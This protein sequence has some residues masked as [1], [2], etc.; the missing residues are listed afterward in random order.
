LS[1]MLTNAIKY[2]KPNGN[3][4][5]EVEETDE[6]YTLR[7]IDDGVGI[8]S[9]DLPHVF[10]K[11]YRSDNDKIRQR[12]GHGLGL[13]LS[14]D[15]VELHHGRVNVESLEGE[16]ATFTLTLSKQNTFHNEVAA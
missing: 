4:T 12:S 1:N 7:V 2:N 14:K 11:F 9:I 3:V 15:I 5:L 16:G 10:E 13:A 6:Q 8:S